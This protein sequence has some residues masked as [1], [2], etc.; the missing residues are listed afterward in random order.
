MKKL[1]VLALLCLFATAC[2][3]PLNSVNAVYKP[4]LPKGK[5]YK[6]DCPQVYSKQP[7]QQKLNK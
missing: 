6:I 5:K 2:K 7:K 4:S 3:T 1:F